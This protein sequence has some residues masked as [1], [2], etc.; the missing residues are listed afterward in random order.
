[1]CACELRE[2]K[3]EMGRVRNGIN[4]RGG[5]QRER[6][7]GE[8]KGTEREMYSLFSSPP[9]L[10]SDYAAWSPLIRFSEKPWAKDVDYAGLDM[11]TILRG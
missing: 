8:E 1:M 4:G 3:E 7:G 5:R 11:Y 9:F 10:H 6:E 2:K